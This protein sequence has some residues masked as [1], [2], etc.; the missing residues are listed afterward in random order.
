MTERRARFKA[1]TRTRTPDR[2]TTSRTPDIKGIGKPAFLIEGPHHGDNG[3]HT[4]V[5]R[6]FI[7]GGI[8]RVRVMGKDLVWIGTWVKDR[9]VPV[10][11]M[12]QISTVLIQRLDQDW[13]HEPR[14]L[15][16]ADGRIFVEDTIDFVHPDYLDNI[17]DLFRAG[18]IA[19]SLH[20]PMGTKEKQNTKI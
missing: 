17:V 1:H 9:Y 4:V 16:A 14:S 6:Q 20:S 13:V 2:S 19:R 5:G 8:A 15:I 18:N 11:R 3:F 12:E 10:N 7:P